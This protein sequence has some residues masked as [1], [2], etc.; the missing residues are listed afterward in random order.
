MDKKTYQIFALKKVFD[1]FENTT[2]AQRIYREIVFL[3]ELGRHQNVVHL[4]N[5]VKAENLR[6]IYLVF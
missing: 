1:A 6:F 4:V 5:V 2:D 3:T